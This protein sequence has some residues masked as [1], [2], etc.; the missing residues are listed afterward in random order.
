MELHRVQEE[1]H[2]VQEELRCS[3][4]EVQSF[5]KIQDEQNAELRKLKSVNET[6]ER[7]KVLL[8][9]KLLTAEET[10]TRLG[11]E[12]SKMRTEEYVDSISNFSYICAF[13]DALRA[14]RQNLSTDQISPLINT[15][16]KY[17]SENPPDRN[18]PISDLKDLCDFSHLPAGVEIED[19]LTDYEDVPDGE[20]TENPSHY[21]QYE[22][23]GGNVGDRQNDRVTTEQRALDGELMTQNVGE[24]DIQGVGDPN[25]QIRQGILSRSLPPTP[26]DE[27]IP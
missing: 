6:L 15:L 12:N 27:F 25:E 3:R 23:G 24:Q 20:A 14:T 19:P 11:L 18:L 2:R 16:E 7:E 5:Q 4:E 8:A 22:Q 10:N 21:H 1:L 9:Q 26:N 17:M 13:A